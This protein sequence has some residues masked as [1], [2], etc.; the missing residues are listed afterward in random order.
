MTRGLLDA[1]N[2]VELEGVV[3]HEMAHVIDR[4]ILLGTIVATLVGSVVLIA[5]F[6]MRMWWWGGSR[7]AGQRFGRRRGLRGDLHGGVLPR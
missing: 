4:D 6:S 3:A 5:E 2:R 1:L 7:P